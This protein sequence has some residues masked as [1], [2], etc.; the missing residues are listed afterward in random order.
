MRIL[1]WGTAT[2]GHVEQE[3]AAGLCEELCC[4][5]VRERQFLRRVYSHSGVRRRGSVLV[6]EGDAGQGRSR[7]FF[8]PRRDA[9]DRG[10]TTRERME[11]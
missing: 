9:G 11:M 7:A 4:G 3:V 10:P 6:D 5:E 2:P 1:G 8:R